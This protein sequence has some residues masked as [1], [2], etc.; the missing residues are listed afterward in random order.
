MVG[1]KFDI[2]E[3]NMCVAKISCVHTKQLPNVSW[4]PEKER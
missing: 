2:S 3:T 4:D 1:C